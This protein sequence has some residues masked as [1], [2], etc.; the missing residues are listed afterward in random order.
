MRMFFAL[1]K[2]E[3]VIVFRDKHALLALFLLPAVFIIIMSYALKDISNSGANLHCLY[4][5]GENNPEDLSEDFRKNMQALQGFACK[6]SKSDKLSKNDDLLVIIPDGFFGSFRDD[7]N[8]SLSVEIS[9]QPTLNQMALYLFEAVL[10]EK[11]ILLYTHEV[12]GEYAPIFLTNLS[13]AFIKSRTSS[14]KIP[15]GTEQSVPSW[16]VFG[17]FFI[18]IPLSTV[19]ITEREQGTY[20]RLKSIGLSPFLFFSAKM[21]AYNIIHIFQ[22]IIL[23]SVGFFVVPLFGMEALGGGNILAIFVLLFS[24]SIAAI[25]FALLIASVCKSPSQA[26]IIGG[27]GNILLGAIGGIMVPKYVMPQMMQQISGL[28]PMSWGLDAFIEIFLYGGGVSDIFK[29]MIFLLLFGTIMFL[30]SLYIFTKREG[31]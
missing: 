25:C 6:E 29:Y 14:L 11:I 23:L 27:V 22:G 16:I 21:A 10:R 5:I 26:V 8:N 18:L 9:H 12:E 24:L 31:D 1:F 15:N 13:K 30:V 20:K 17:M 4:Y 7:A 3:C 19:L 2:K 28:S